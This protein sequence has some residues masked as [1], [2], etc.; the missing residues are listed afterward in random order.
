MS[1]GER[2]LL[3]DVNVVAQDLV[4]YFNEVVA[5]PEYRGLPAFLFGFVSDF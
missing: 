2:G 5:A 3:K 4:D 1:D